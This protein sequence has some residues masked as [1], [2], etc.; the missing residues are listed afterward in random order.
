MLHF[1]IE[2]ADENNEGLWNLQK[3]GCFISTCPF[4]SQKV[5]RSKSKCFPRN[6]FGNLARII[7]PLGIRQTSSLYVISSRFFARNANIFIAT[8]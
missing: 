7:F 5:R 6:S 3:K 8:G 1:R 2:S 4:D